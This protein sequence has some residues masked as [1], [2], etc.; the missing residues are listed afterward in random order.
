MKTFYS[1]VLLVFLV[2]C[3]TE[4]PIDQNP[5]TSNVQQE[6]AAEIDQTVESLPDPK[7]EV[8]ELLEQVDEIAEEDDSSSQVQSSEVVEL[9]TTYTNPAMEVVMNIEY[10]LDSEDKISEISV[11]SPNYPGMPDFNAWVQPVV[12]M[13]VQEASEYVVSGSSLTTPV[14]QEALKNS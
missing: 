1:L 2:S 7:Q 10:S 6:V 13:T 8:D 5:E 14:F 9:S 11:T 12:G 3:W 4:A